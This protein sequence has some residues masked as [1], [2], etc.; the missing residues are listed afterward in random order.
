MEKAIENEVQAWEDVHAAN[1]GRFGGHW[2]GEYPS[3]AERKEERFKKALEKATAQSK[4]RESSQREVVMECTNEKWKFTLKLQELEYKEVIL[5]HEV[6]AEGAQVTRPTHKV[7]QA[8]TT[9][10]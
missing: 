9:V 4:A 1:E 6:A 8:Y 7:V 2:W 5:M 3:V 10:W